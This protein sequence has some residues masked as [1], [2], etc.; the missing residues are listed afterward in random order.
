MNDSVILRATELAESVSFTF[1]VDGVPREGNET[2]SL[3]LV[4]LAS[5]LQTMPNGE[6]V[7]FLNSMELTIMDADGR[8]LF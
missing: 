5:T 6:A 7:Y 8:I 1:L 4:P 2:L 3:N